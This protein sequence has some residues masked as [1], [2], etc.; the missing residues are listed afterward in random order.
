M[1]SRDLFTTKIFSVL[2]DFIQE[3]ASNNDLIF[4]DEIVWCFY[5]LFIVDIIDHYELEIQSQTEDSFVSFLTEYFSHSRYFRLPQYQIYANFVTFIQKRHAQILK[6]TGLK[7]IS[8]LGDFHVPLTKFYKNDKVYYKNY[9]NIDTTVVEIT[10]ILPEFKKFFPEFKINPNG[11]IERN[12]I[13][14]DEEIS[15]FQYYYYNLGLAISFLLTFRGID[16]NIE[17]I[18][19]SQN[20]PNFFDIEFLFTPLFKTVLTK[21]NISISSLLNDTNLDDVSAINPGSKVRTFTRPYIYTNVNGIDLLWENKFNKIRQ[22]IP[23]N[24]YNK[25]AVEF[26]DF[27]LDGFDYGINLIYNQKNE[28]IEVMRKT[29][30]FTRTILKPTSTYRYAIMSTIYEKDNVED[31]LRKVLTSFGTYN[32]YVLNEEQV[33]KDEVSSLLQN[34]IPY[35]KI[36]LNGKEIYSDQGS[37]VGSV[38]YTPVEYT[39]NQINNI[40]HF[41]AIQKRMIKQKL[42]IGIKE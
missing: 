39:I 13:K 10:D 11:Y 19:I 34:I 14:V 20:L 16:L 41:A 32:P 17:N 36:P 2:K 28:I 8:F 3:Y 12:F 4:N 6:E 7:N 22:N 33:L 29:N 15:D 26:I 42:L 35:Y 1:P 23:A 24:F 9:L 27:I 18:L 21:Y 25:K 40:R 31:C 37:I 5:D 38:E 30:S